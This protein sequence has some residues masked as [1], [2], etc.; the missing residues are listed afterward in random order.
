MQNEEL[1]RASIALETS[2]AHYR[3]LY[4][5]APVGYLTLTAGGMITEINHTG[6]E[7]LGMPSKDI[8]KRR[9]DGFIA[10]DYKDQWYRHCRLMQQDGKH[11]IELPLRRK[12]GAHLYAQLDCLPIKTQDTD[13]MLRI[14]LTDITERKQIQEALQESEDRLNFAFKSSGDGMWDWNVVTGEVH[15]ST[16]WKTMLGYHDNEVKNDFKEWEKRV[17]PDDLQPAMDDIQRYLSGA[18]EYYANEHRL[19]C[20]DGSYKWILTRGIVRT[21]SPDGRPVRLIGTHTDITRHRQ[22]EADLRIA[23]AAFESQNG[24]MVTD[25]DR[26]IMRV[27]RAFSRITDYSAEEIIGKP[28]ALLRSGLHQDN[29]YADLWTSLAHTSYWQGELWTKRKNG[30]IFPSWH[31]MTAVTDKDGGIIHYV[32][33]F[34]DISA[35]KQAEKVL[36]EARQRLENQVI[37]SIEKLKKNKQKTTE[38][39]TALNVLLKHRETDKFDAKTAFSTEIETTVLPFLEKLKR[40]NAGRKQSIRL[41]SILE[42]N[43]DRLVE[44]YGRDSNLLAAYHQLTPVETQVATM[45]RQGLASKVIAATLNIASST[46]GIHR[47]H[48]R[49]KLGLLNKTI[50]LQSYLLSLDD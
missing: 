28:A 5:F 34:L 25:S 12:D 29:F 10:D 37:D 9:F 2:R 30:E 15:Y 32:D 23:A 14:A 7:L 35:Q 31:T 39:N 20:K 47:K 36:L 16:Q 26:V 41:I 44:A 38:I 18:A 27:N 1:R 43:L 42:T 8:I 22:I 50:N 13:P 4:D 11:S 33:T 21:R 46:V 49:K 24:I 45:I 6:A 40:A 17:H 48:I 19:L 3:E